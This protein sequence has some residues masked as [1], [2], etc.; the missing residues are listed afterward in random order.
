MAGS[1]YHRVRVRQTVAVARKPRLGWG[2]GTDRPRDP[3]LPTTRR[4]LQ[5]S[6]PNFA[7]RP[8]PRGRR[9]LGSHSV[10]PSRRSSP[11]SSP[12]SAGRAAGPGTASHSG[13][14]PAGLRRKDQP[15]VAQRLRY[16]N[17]PPVDPAPLETATA[18]LVRSALVPGGRPAGVRPGGPSTRQIA[19]GR[20]CGYCDWVHLRSSSPWLN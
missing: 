13:C 5:G 14:L 15:Y 8:R 7:D 6:C 3:P 1:A 9:S 11:G 20:G 19:W 4:P 10:R 2:P 16:E 12:N 18:L 17:L